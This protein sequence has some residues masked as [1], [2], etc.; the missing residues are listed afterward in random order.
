[1]AAM[2]KGDMATMEDA[3]D[4]LEREWDIR[5]ENGKSL[6]WLFKKHR[7]LVEDGAPTPQIGQ[8]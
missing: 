7:L 6:W 3:R 8:C 4:Y 2:R 1:M 5:Y